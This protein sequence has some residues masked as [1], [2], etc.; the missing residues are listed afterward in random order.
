M[1]IPTSERPFD[2]L[3]TEL[4]SDR[5]EASPTLA[6]DLGLTEYDHLLPDMSA[7]A[8]RARDRR[9]DE[10][11]L[12]LGDLPTADLTDDEVL[13][14]DLV[15]MVLRGNSRD[16]RLGRLAAQSRSLC[17]AGAGRRLRPADAPAAS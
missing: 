7:D 13:D 15:L 9:D 3:A 14:R 2:K 8:I 11:T 1:P 4:A 17:R 16:A 5:F 12:R 10:W 6:S